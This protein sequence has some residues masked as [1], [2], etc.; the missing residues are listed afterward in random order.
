MVWIFLCTSTLLPPC[1]QWLFM[2]NQNQGQSVFLARRRLGEGLAVWWR[3]AGCHRPS[4][5]HRTWALAVKQSEWLAFISPVCTY[6]IRSVRPLFLARVRTTLLY[7]NPYSCPPPSKTYLK[8]C[9]SRLYL[10]FL[11]GGENYWSLTNGKLAETCIR[12]LS[13]REFEKE[14]GVSSSQ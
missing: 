1:S 9:S 8:T 13:E 11:E 2:W 12:H 14:R 7:P 10:S 5:Q 3:P 4:R 6:E